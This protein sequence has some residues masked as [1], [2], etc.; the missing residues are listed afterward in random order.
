MVN[1]YKPAPHIQLYAICKDDS[2]P[3]FVNQDWIQ[4]ERWYAVRGFT[5]P[6]NQSDGQGLIIL[7]NTGREL[8]ASEIH[9]SFSSLRFDII[10]FNLN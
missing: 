1:V 10:E 3:K 5:E 9:W 8:H 2:R 6:L 7:D 4:K